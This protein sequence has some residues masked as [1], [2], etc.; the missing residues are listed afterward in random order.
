MGQLSRFK[1]EQVDLFGHSVVVR[2][3]MNLGGSKENVVVTFLAKHLGG[4][5]TFSEENPQT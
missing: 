1:S 5:F 4:L 2:G 3:I